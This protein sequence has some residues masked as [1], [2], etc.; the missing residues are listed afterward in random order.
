MSNEESVAEGFNGNDEDIN[1]PLPFEELIQESDIAVD[2]VHN[3]LNVPDN[4]DSE[5]K[6]GG[7]SLPD[8][9]ALLHVTSRRKLHLNRAGSLLVC[10]HLSAQDLLNCKFD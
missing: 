6:W 5:D 9:H 2:D 10:V 4:F 3:D 8:R 1:L 7:L